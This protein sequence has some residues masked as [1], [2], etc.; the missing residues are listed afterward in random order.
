[1]SDSYR[2][3]P[4]GV[5]PHTF[6]QEHGYAFAFFREPAGAAARAALRE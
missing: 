5:P 3:K 2:L 6:W 4:H 1:M